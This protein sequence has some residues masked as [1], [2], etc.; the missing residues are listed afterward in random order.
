M[1]CNICNKD[2]HTTRKCPH[3]AVIKKYGENVCYSC[4]TKC[5]QSYFQVNELRCK[6]YKVE[7]IGNIRED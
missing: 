6:L 4:C 2:W 1:K 5:N 3:P 7:N